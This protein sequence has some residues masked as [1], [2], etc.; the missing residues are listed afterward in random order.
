M[1][2]EQWREISD[3][4]KRT[5]DEVRRAA[6]PVW[7][8]MKPRVAEGS[9]FAASVAADLKSR[10]QAKSSEVE[11]KADDTA[12]KIARFGLDVGGLLADAVGKGADWVGRKSRE[13]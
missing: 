13:P 11:S 2:N 6:K 4:L 3:D 12:A 10:A 9:D 8:Q 7:E 5:V 1:A